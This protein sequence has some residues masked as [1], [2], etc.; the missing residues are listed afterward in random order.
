MNSEPSRLK[1]G[2]VTTMT[3]TVIVMVITLNL[4]TNLTKG[5]YKLI[6]I[7]AIGFLC[8]GI[9]FPLITSVMRAGVSVIDINDAKSIAKVFV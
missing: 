4:S 6:R 7:L 1:T 8:S 3:A 9:I 2:Y 5:V